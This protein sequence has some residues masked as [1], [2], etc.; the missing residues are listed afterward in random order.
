LNCRAKVAVLNN[1]RP[2]SLFF[3]SDQAPQGSPIRGQQP[4]N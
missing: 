2:A 1:L 3:T 4:E